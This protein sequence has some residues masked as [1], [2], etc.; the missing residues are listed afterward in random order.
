M[1]DKTLF[2]SLYQMVPNEI[3]QYSGIVQLLIHF[4]WT[5]VGLFAVDDD[6]GER[7]FQTLVPILSSNSICSAFIKRTPKWTYVADILDLF[8]DDLD[9]FPSLMESKA[10]VFIVHGAPPSMLNLSWYLHM[11]VFDSNLGKVWIVT[12]QWDFRLSVYQ[13]NWDI[14]FFQGA[15]SFS[16]HSNE[17]LGFKVFLENVNPAWETEDGFIQDFWENV[18][19]CSMKNYSVISEEEPKKICTGE[20]KLE[21]LPGTFFEMKMTGH[22][23]N[24]YN[25]AYAIAHALHVI[26][27]FRSKSR[28]KVAQKSLKVLSFQPWQVM[29]LPKTSF[30]FIHNL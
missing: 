28:S 15:L 20:E 14:Q 1:N 3:Q 30:I 12:E 27:E 18:F 19:S 5:W 26:H 13:K 29:L 9:K 11:A 24:V 2:A 8:L 7:F 16:V 21:N 10:N 4:R 6:N 23:Y 25:A 17:I 22:S